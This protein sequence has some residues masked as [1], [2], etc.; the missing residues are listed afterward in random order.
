V[1]RFLSDFRKFAM[2]GNLLQVA[3]AFIIGLYFKDVIDKFTNGIVL[4]LIAAI[5]GKSN[6]VDIDVTVNKSVIAVGAF[7]NAIINFLLVAL[8]LFLMIRAWE[9]MRERMRLAQDEEALTPDQ[10]LL[11]QI[12]DL[13]AAQSR[14][15]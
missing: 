3:V 12:R 2:Q 6:F 5:F 9:S 10:E 8:V 13:L 7:L 4:A 1:R 14:A 11:T 15:D